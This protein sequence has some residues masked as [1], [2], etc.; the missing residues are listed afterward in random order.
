MLDDYH[1]ITLE[2][3]QHAIASLVEHCP[4]HLHLVITSRSDPRLPLARLRARGQLCEIRATDLQFDL[5]KAGYFLHI[6]LER[7]LESS[8]IATILSRTEGWIV[9]LQLTALLLQGQRTEADV[10][11]FLADTLGTHRYLVEYLGEEVFSRQPL[12]VQ[13]FLLQTCI[14][15][16][17]SAPLCAAVSRISEDESTAMLDSLERANLSSCHSTR[18]ASGIA[19]TRSG[20]RY[21]ACSSCV[22]WEQQASRTSMREPAA[23]MSCMTC[24]PRRLK[25]PSRPTSSSEASSWSSN[26]ARC[27]LPA[28]SITPCDTGLNACPMTCGQSVP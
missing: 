16:R 7:D 2:P 5:A 15:E 20:L 8:T 11:Q 10:R 12:D 19:L 22:S 1:I 17:F 13:S 4:P 27:C 26:K 14:L 18:E 28:P 3:L 21:C 9:G 23:G 6:A 24:P 25:L